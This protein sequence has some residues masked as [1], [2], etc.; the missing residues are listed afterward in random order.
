MKQVQNAPC[1]KAVHLSVSAVRVN[2]INIVI[3]NI[4]ILIPPRRVS[5][6]DY[7]DYEIKENFVIS[8]H[9]EN[10]HFLQHILC[11]LQ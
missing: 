3:F 7:V 2:I 11:F 4:L 8:L 6:Y 1:N 10:L 5:R 9:M